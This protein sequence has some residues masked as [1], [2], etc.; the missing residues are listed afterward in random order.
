MRKRAVTIE[1]CVAN[2]EVEWQTLVQ[3][4]PVLAQA[5]CW[6]RRLF[7]EV[8]LFLCLLGAVGWWYL[9]TA[10]AEQVKPGVAAVPQEAIAWEQKL[11]STYFRFHYRQQDAAVVATV[12]PRLDTLYATVRRNFGLTPAPLTEKRLIEVSVSQSPADKALAP[13]TRYQPSVTLSTEDWLLQALALPLLDEALAQINERDPQAA[14]WQP[15][16]NGLRLWQL[17]D[18]NLPLTHWRKEIVTWYYGNLFQPE[19]AHAM[20]LPVHYSELCAAHLR[21]LSSP[22][23]IHIPLFCNELDKDLK[24]KSCSHSLPLRL[25][26]LAA[27]ISTPSYVEMSSRTSVIDHCDDAIAW[28]TLVEY[29]VA[30]Y[31]RD[32]LP[33]LV[34]GLGQFESWETLLPAVYGVSAAEFET[35]W[36]TYLATH[37][38]FVE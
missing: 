38:G 24:G 2:D 16:L 20:R 12:A 15:W 31:G 30:T 8:A 23:Q 21:W 19:P 25:A 10:E 7:G 14:P 36:Q 34:A 5:R 29:A 26:D 11:E 32:R 13:A 35:G 17:W 33:A 27:P 4:T 18:L 22:L 3:P 9:T 37:Y 28:A 6:S 1:W